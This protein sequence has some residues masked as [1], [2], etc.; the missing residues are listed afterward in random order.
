MRANLRATVEVRFGTQQAFAKVAEIHPIRLNKIVNAW[1]D[2]TPIEREQFSE[3]LGVDVDW[4]F[5]VFTIPSADHTATATGE[6]N[7]SLREIAAEL[8]RIAT[9]F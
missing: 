3:L 2:P 8:S 7:G 1:I 4:L 6:D 5:R 9:K